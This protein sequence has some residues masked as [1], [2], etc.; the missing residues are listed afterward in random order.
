MHFDIR[1]GEDTPVHMCT[2]TGFWGA[3]LVIDETIRAFTY[4]KSGGS[5]EDSNDRDDEGDKLNVK[6]SFM[7]PW[8]FFLAT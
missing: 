7:L 6:C 2:A 3:G 5:E 1:N 4:G 8:Y